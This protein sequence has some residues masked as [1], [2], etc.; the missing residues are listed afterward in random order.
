MSILSSPQ[1]R[2]ER[3]YSLYRART[4]VSPEITNVL[5]RPFLSPGFESDGE[6]IIMKQE[7]LADVFGAAQVFDLPEMATQTREFPLSYE[8]FLDRLHSKLASLDA[9]HIESVLLRSFAFFV[10]KSEREGN[11]SW[12]DENRQGIEDQI[13]SALSSI[14]DDS[15]AMNSTKFTAWRKWMVALGLM[16]PNPRAKSLEIL[17]VSGRL[18]REL[19]GPSFE[20]VGVMS[21]KDFLGRVART[22]PYLDGGVM[23]NE[24][25]QS[26]SVTPRQGVVS[27]VLSYALQDLH[28]DRVLSLS[29]QGDGAGS[30]QLKGD[31]LHERQSFMEVDLGRNS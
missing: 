1:G 20:N 11:T 7:L 10:V 21:A 25:S 3:V 30:Y 15:I 6:T 4:V 9:N 27:R 2:P 16:V 12:L 23:Y 19:R 5:M 13:T 17:D 24:L 18:E 29:L 22:M 14:S 26:L 31:D 28:T 8:N